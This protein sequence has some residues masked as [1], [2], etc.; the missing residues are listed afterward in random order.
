MSKTVRSAELQLCAILPSDERRTGPR[1][2]LALA[3]CPLVAQSFTLLYRRVALCEATTTRALR[4]A[5][6]HEPD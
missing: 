3:G 2:C 1:M 4:S 6:A 5:F